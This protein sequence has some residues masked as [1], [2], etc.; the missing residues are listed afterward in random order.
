MRASAADLERFK[1]LRIISDFV[2]DTC[3]PL[4]VGAL[5]A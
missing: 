2:A 4:L 5:L 3:L 1:F